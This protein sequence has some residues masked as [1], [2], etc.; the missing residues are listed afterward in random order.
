MQPTVSVVI[1]VYNTAK[2]YLEPSLKSAI[3]ANN[4]GVEVIIVDDGSKNEET[5]QLCD[6]FSNESQNVLVFHI[7]NAGVSAA[8]N[9]GVQ[10][11]NGE[12]VLFLDS[13]DELTDDAFDEL[14]KAV[15]QNPV[16]IVLFDY[17]KVFGGRTAEIKYSKAD[18][19]YENEN[20]Y[21]ILKDSLIVEKG[22]ALC[23]AKIFR[24]SFLLENNLA[25]N[26]K[27]VAA[28][29]ADFA[30]SCYCAAKRILYLSKSLYKYNV[31]EESAVR[32]YKK[33]MPNNYIKS[34]NHIIQVIKNTRDDVL[35]K[36][37]YNFSLYHLLLIIVNNVFS[38]K[39]TA[40]LKEKFLLLD[41]IGENGCFAEAI[42]YLDYSLFSKTRAITLFLY[43]HRLYFLV[44][45]IALFRQ[46]TR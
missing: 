28:E 24:R 20:C 34:M 30:I 38:K 3:R 36:Y 46:S 37:V 21:E 27:L 11:A 9:F 42:K 29:D 5:I 18:R 19:L 35:L 25:F 33:D 15:S 4:P 12:Y 22:L 26:K 17:Y 1:P 40:T 39:N 31:F 16:D 8:R 44:Y 14:L 10:K 45:L 2:E 6:S 7:E 41:K 13:D 23:W 43:K 32:S